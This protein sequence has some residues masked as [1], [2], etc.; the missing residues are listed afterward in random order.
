M[1][2]PL[3]PAEPLPLTVLVPV[4]NEAGNVAPLKREVEAALAGRVAYEL[5]FVDDGSSDTTLD[6]LKALKKAD[7]AMRVVVHG[8]RCGKSAALVTGMR[9]ARGIWVQTLD[10]DLQDDPAD[11]LPALAQAMRQDAPVRLG[12]VAGQ[13]KKRNDGR[14]KSLSS[15]I[16]NRVRKRLLND[17]TSDTGCGFKLMRREAFA[18]V[19]FFDGMH[20]FLPALMRRGGWE[21]ETM[22]VNNRPRAAGT[23]KYGIW[24]RFWVGLFDLWGVR[25]LNRR[26]RFP[27]ATEC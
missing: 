6:E 26:A 23:S 4:Y 16:A 2:E 12:I 19:A 7:P 20:R 5:L 27:Q 1:S 11:I 22:P 17:G 24:G 13:R 21:I 10:G 25:W 14:L 15:K 9:A 18:D 8:E 3:A